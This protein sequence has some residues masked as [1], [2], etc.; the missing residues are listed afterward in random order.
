MGILL[1]TDGFLIRRQVPVHQKKRG[2]GLT[3]DRASSICHKITDA[4][5]SLESLSKAVMAGAQRVSCLDSFLDCS[6]GS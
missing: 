3:S 6:V 4:V 1:D 5:L 2:K